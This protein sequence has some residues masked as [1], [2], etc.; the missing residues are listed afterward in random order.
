MTFPKISACEPISVL[1]KP[2][3]NYSW[4][5]CGLSETQPFCD[6]KH[7]QDTCQMSPLKLQFAEEKEVWLCQCKHT[8]NPP[9]CD[10]THVNLRE[11]G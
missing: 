8:S 2:G 5:A 7:K 1:V 9:F 3:K 11:K 6:G 4:C 10:G